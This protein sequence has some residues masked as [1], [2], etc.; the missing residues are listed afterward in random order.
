MHQL[1]FRIFYN[2]FK[3]KK[4]SLH[5]YVGSDLISLSVS[6]EKFYIQDESPLIMMQQPRHFDRERKPFSDYLL[7]GT[8][9]DR[10]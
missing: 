6:E 10:K 5:F 2:T 4:S 8:K 3:C 7:S 1:N 9:K